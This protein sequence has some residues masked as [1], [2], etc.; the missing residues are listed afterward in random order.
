MA[1]IE[2]SL[3][4]NIKYKSGIKNTY[5]FEVRRTFVDWEDHKQTCVFL[6]MEPLKTILIRGQ[7][8]GWKLLEYA[9]DSKIRVGYQF[10][11]LIWAVV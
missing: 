2:I 7:I 10:S 3:F 11:R 4:L 5:G 8:Q 6:E 1:I 9:M